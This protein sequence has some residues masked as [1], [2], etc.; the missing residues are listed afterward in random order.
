MQRRLEFSQTLNEMSL[1]EQLNMRA[2]PQLAP[3]QSPMID[4]HGNITSPNPNLQTPIGQMMAL[5]H[6]VDDLQR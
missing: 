2:F 4:Y 3:S 1:R 6:W 5:K